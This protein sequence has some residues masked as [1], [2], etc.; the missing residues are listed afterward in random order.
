MR[1]F[2]HTPLGEW[3]PLRVGPM[4]QGKKEAEAYSGPPLPDIDCSSLE[5]AG[6]A[7]LHNVR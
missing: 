2:H 3:V 7:R 5:K 1:A 4:D 6:P